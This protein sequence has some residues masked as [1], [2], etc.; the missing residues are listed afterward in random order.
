MSV[1]GGGYPLSS[2]TLVLSCRGGTPWP[3]VPGPFLGVTP[4]RHVAVWGTSVR[5]VATGAGQNRST[6]P[7]DMTGGNLPPQ[8]R[9]CHGRYASYGHAGGLSCIWNRCSYVHVGWSCLP[10]SRS[11]LLVLTTHFPLM[12]MSRLPGLH[13]VP[14]I[15]M[16]F[17]ITLKYLFFGLQ[18]S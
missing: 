10:V 9:R 17:N 13:G 1:H 7:P 6:P 3:L 4:V 11:V 8:D 12:H 15:T 14:S 18:C 2:N 16:S 5:P